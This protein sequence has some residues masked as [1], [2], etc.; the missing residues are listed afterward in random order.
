MGRGS[1]NGEKILFGLERLCT[2]CCSN[3]IADLTKLGD[4]PLYTLRRNPAESVTLVFFIADPKYGNENVV[5]MVRTAGSGMRGS[6]CS[7]ISLFP[8]LN[9]LIQTSCCC[10]AEGSDTREISYMHS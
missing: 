2:L 9:A 3:P 6:S 10:S 1:R 8:L 5:V 7:A 4:N